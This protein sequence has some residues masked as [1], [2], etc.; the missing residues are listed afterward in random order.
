[1]FYQPDTFYKGAKV[2]QVRAVDNGNFQTLDF[3]GWNVTAMPLF[4]R[5]QFLGYGWLCRNS[6]HGMHRATTNKGPKTPPSRPE[7]PWL[8]GPFADLPTS[9]IFKLL[10]PR[11]CMKTCLLYPAQTFW[12]LHLHSVESDWLSMLLAFLYMTEAV[13]GLCAR[14]VGGLFVRRSVVTSTGKSS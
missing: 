12:C 10:F 4:N 5:I 7:G 11:R 3:H 6:G 1:M 9:S 14:S 13:P 2:H 8:D